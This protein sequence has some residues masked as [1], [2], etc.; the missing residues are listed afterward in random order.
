MVFLGADIGVVN[1]NHC[2]E[3]WI[4][5]R[6]NIMFYT[7]FISIEIMADSF[8]IK[9]TQYSHNFLKKWA[10]W[11]FIE[12]ALPVITNKT[13]FDYFYRSHGV[14]NGVLQLVVLEAVLPNAKVEYANCYEQF[15]TAY[16]LN[17]ASSYYGFVLC[18]RTVLG[19]EYFWPGKIKIYR[20]GLGWARDGG[21]LTY[22]DWSEHDFMIHD[23]KG[24][25]ITKLAYW[26]KPA[27]LLKEW[28]SPFLSMLNISECGKGYSGWNWRIEKKKSVEE[29]KKQLVESEKLFQDLFLKP[30]RFNPLI[31]SAR[32]DKCYPKCDK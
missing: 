20:K 12:K 16:D 24:D 9:N 32:I 7:R 18:V 3:E 28:K 25:D 6:V 10:N 1:P 19:S 23:W 29:I 22:D 5:D 31:D 2:I 8:I 27:S 15:N 17:K 21:H 11:E 4:D 14:D 13:T 26:H 30:H